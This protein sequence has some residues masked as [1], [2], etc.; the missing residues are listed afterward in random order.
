MLWLMAYVAAKEVQNF[1]PAGVTDT[2][3]GMTFI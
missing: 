2:A 3:Q 1:N